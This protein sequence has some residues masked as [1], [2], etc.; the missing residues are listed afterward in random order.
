PTGRCF[1][2]HPAPASL[3]GFDVFGWAFDTSSAVHLRSSSWPSP[4][5]VAP[6]LFRQRSPPRNYSRSSL[7]WF[8]TCPCPTDSEG[9]PLIAHAAQLLW[10]FSRTSF[11]AFVTHGRPS[12]FQNLS[13]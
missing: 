1:R 9:P 7:R 11:R 13:V 2:V 8:G 3:R 12:H 10:L 5:A 4:D 6:R